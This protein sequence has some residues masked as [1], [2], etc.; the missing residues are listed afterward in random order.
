MT[1]LYIDLETYSEVPIKYGVHAYAEK[2]EILL[3]AW[4]LDDN[5][6]QVF[7]GSEPWPSTLLSAMTNEAVT[8]HAH[9]SGFDRVILKHHGFTILRNRWRDTMVQALAHSL[10]GGLGDLCDVLGVPQD[11]AKDKEGRQLIL[12]F[13]K[14][15]GKTSKLHRATKDT[16]PKKW[17]AFKRY[18]RLDIEAMREVEKRLPSW[19]YKG[20]ELILWHLDQRIND[21]GVQVDIALAKSAVD[22]IDKEQKRLSKQAQ[23]LS[24]DVVQ[25]ATQRDAMLKHIYDT[26]DITLPDL[27]QSTIERRLNDPDIPEGLKNLLNIRLQASTTST[28]KY[29]A[30]LGAVS[31]DGRLRGTMQFCGASRTGRWSGRLF[32]PQNLPRPTLPNNLIDTGIEALKLGCA[33]LVTDNIMQLTSS[34]IRGCLIAPEGRK[35]VIADLSNIE[36]RMLAWLAGEE[37]KLKAFKDY[38]AGKG[39][40]LYKLAYASSFGV[41]PESVTKEQRQIGKVQELALGYEGGVGAFITFASAYGIDLDDMADKALSNIPKDIARESTKAY[42]WALERKGTHG[43]SKKAYIIC[44]AFKRLW[45]NAH[46]QTAS[47]WKELDD[48]V[49]YAIATPNKNFTSRKVIVRRDGNWLRIGLPS[50]RSLC[51]PNPKIEDGKISYMGTN[52]YSRKWE[53]LYTYGGKL[54]IAKGT[55]VLTKKGWTAIEQVTVNDF[56]WDGEQWVQTQGA[57]YKGEKPVINAYGALMTADHLVLS[58]KGWIHASQSKGY[59]RFTCRLP[60]GVIVPRQRWEKITLEGWLSLWKNVS[61]SSKRIKENAKAR[62]KSLLR[63]YEEAKHWGEKGNAQNVQAPS[64]CRMAVN[65]CSVFSQKPQSVPKLRGQRNLRLSSVEGIIRT[66]LAGYGQE[67]SNRINTGSSRQ[68]RQLHSPKLSVDDVRRTGKQHQKREND[69]GYKFIKVCSRAWRK[70][71]NFTLPLERERVE[72]RATDRKSEFCTQV[73]DLLNCGPLNRFVIAAGGKPLIVHNCENITQACAR[74]ILAQSMPYIEEAGYA[75]VLS[76]HDEL[77]TETPDTDKF[78]HEKLAELMAFTPEWAN[79][80]PLAAAG[81]E[82]YR[83]RKD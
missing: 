24:G 22:A 18:A 30:L 69:R 7:E 28:A 49:R 80:L 61:N 4:A 59:N 74:D 52:Q 38:D 15:L 57:I 36:G 48:T 81:F 67:L 65:A 34:A 66:V 29:K 25:A 51:Y 46:P 5:P 8:V 6:V 20:R 11:K 3:V 1:R 54:C 37:W 70:V 40:D 62:Y 13:T 42:D 19:N 76:V 43:L 26:Y 45:R 12:L 77:I 68:Q 63:M 55:P 9:N 72:Q 14:P 58:E 23:T 64:L 78:T 75:I 16:H 17:E 39:H 47:W 27:Q 2:S 79:G 73:Y 60:E 21:R 41:K 35:L 83:Y 33:D 82:T 53:R 56:V 71:L 10:P 50:G 32:Q 31:S 44:D